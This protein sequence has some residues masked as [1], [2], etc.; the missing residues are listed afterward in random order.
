[1]STDQSQTESKTESKWRP[2][3]IVFDLLTA[4]MDSWSLWDASTPSKTREEGK[5]WREH[6]LKLTFSAGEYVPY[7]DLIWKSA[8]EL[9]LPRSAPEALLRDW[10]RLRPWPEA[11]LVLSKLRAKGYILGV[12]TN[13]SSPLGFTAYRRVEK[14]GQANF[15][16][17]SVITAEMSG[18]YKPVK[19]AYEHILGTIS[20]DDPGDVLF[21]AG[22]AGDV[23]GATDAG[24]K[25]V[26][27]NRIGLP[28][29]GDAVPL[30]EGKTLHDTLKDFL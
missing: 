29:V 23:Q 15:S 14:D 25:V 10:R 24:M 3:A 17:D 20:V 28:R 7:Q 18:Y 22:S 12:V 19:K 8:S 27:H 16:F 9:G 5:R 13:C 1:M 2:K 30:R 11:G 4:L 6:Y 21:V 26:W